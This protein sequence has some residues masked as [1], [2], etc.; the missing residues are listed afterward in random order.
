MKPLCLPVKMMQAF[1]YMAANHT[2]LT[3]AVLPAGNRTAVRD[4]SQWIAA[5]PEYDIDADKQC[6]DYDKCKYHLQRLTG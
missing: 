3:L 6:Y 2:V 4:P 1:L 5:F